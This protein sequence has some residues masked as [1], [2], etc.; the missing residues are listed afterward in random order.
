MSS[1]VRCMP[2]HRSDDTDGHWWGLAGHTNAKWCVAASFSTTD[3]NGK[4]IVS[5]SEDGGIVIWDLNR[6]EVHPLPPPPPPPPTHTHTHTHTHGCKNR[7][8]PGSNLQQTFR[9]L[10]I[11]LKLI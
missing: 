4:W 5:G 8:M 9:L 2:V 11:D 7:N 10:A 6:K 3:P 1:D